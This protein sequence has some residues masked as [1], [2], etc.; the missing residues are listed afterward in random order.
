MTRL[1]D[2]I[3]G[4]LKDNYVGRRL[5]VEEGQMVVVVGASVSLLNPTMVQLKL[6][7]GSI[8]TVHESQ[9]HRHTCQMCLKDSVGVDPEYLCILEGKVWEQEDTDC[10]WWSDVLCPDHVNEARKLDHDA[11]HCG[12]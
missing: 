8:I 4:Y 3:E 7:T 5:V 6:S 12:G 1:A 2:L 10:R 11:L 9:V